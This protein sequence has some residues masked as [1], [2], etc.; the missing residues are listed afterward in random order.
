MQKE[1]IPQTTDA[2]STF[3]REQE[4]YQ[5]KWKYVHLFTMTQGLIAV[6]MIVWTT[7]HIGNQYYKLW[8]FMF[9]LAL[10]QSLLQTSKGNSAAAACLIHQDVL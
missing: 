7:D 6:V 3:L 5:R 10:I 8:I 1:E 9:T 2:I 4:E